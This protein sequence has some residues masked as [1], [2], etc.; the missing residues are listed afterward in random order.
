[1][2]ARFAVFATSLGFGFVRKI[3]TVVIALI[4]LASS[5]QSASAQG[6][7]EALFGR[8]WSS[9]PSAYADPS[10]QLNPFGGRTAPSSEA[11]GTAYCVRP[12]DGRFFPIQR[13]A[14]V[15]PAQACSSF[16]PASADQD[17][18]RQHH[19]ACDGAGRQ[20]LQR[21]RRPPSPIGT[22]SSRAAPATARTRSG[23]SPP[24]STTTRRC[25]PAI[26]LPPIPADG[27]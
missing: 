7:F 23:W 14:G 24:A 6:I 4:A 10:S 25:A 13:H 16:C 1:M 12:C 20:A 21:A 5:L 26:S 18:Q 9:A 2:G 19:R 11:T 27:L 3:F 17:L 22:R 15:S 8:P